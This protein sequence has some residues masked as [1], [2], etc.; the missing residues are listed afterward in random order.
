VPTTTATPSGSWTHHRAKIGALSRSRPADDPE[1]LQAYAD[2]NETRRPVLES[3]AQAAAQAAADKI[4]HCIRRN[5]AQAPPFSDAQRAQLILLLG[6]GP[7]VQAAA[8][9]RAENS[10]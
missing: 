2:L 3:Q 10:A 5:V 4:A 8:D 1:L 9:Q 7:A 6:G